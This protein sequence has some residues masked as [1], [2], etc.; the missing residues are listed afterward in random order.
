MIEILEIWKEK[1]ESGEIY[2][3]EKNNFFKFIVKE[4]IIKE[5]RD[6]NKV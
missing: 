1:L 5:R 2:Y 3:T 6:F 4:W